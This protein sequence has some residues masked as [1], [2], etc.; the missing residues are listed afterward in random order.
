MI[1]KYIIILLFFTYNQ[2]LFSDDFVSIKSNKINMRTGAGIH[3][4]IK[5]V[6]TKKNLPLKVVEKFE[7]WKKV[8]DIN[9]DCGWIKST[10]LSNKRYVML[11]ENTL[12]YKKQNIE[13]EVLMKID[14]FAIMEIKKYTKDWCLLS[15]LK[16]KAW[17]QKKFIWGVD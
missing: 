11:K 17:V 14:K 15:A 5:W 16:R 8:C 6:Y 12:G 13:S 3:Y 2:S 10:L 7:N 9:E 1:N 4:P